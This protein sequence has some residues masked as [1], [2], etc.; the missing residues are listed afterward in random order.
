METSQRPENEGATTRRTQ[1]PSSERQG[2][3]RA[4]PE[5]TSESSAV[6]T[7][8]ARRS[9][10]CTTRLP[11]RRGQA[12][13]QPRAH[14]PR[15]RRNRARVRPPPGRS[16]PRYASPRAYAMCSE[17]SKPPIGG[18]QRVPRAIRC[19]PRPR[20][21][22]VTSRSKGDPLDQQPTPPGVEHS[23][24]RASNRHESS[25][26]HSGTLPRCRRAALHTS[27]FVVGRAS[28]LHEWRRP[29]TVSPPARAESEPSH[30]GGDT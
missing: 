10:S 21:P 23:A 5:S 7:Q 6:P 16:S 17:A 12:H 9:R 25:P 20:S 28:E 1:A 29:S 30:A 2:P 27:C 19:E 13:H 15:E 26:V 4:T 24:F 18:T 11:S 14:R 22:H 8:R 3:G